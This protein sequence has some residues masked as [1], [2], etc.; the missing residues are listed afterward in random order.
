M[1]VNREIFTEGKVEK[2]L[3]KF[4]IPAIM[5]LLVSELYNMVDTFFVGRYVGPEAI[6][7]LTIAFPIQRLM[8]SI[9]LCIAVGAATNVATYLGK[10]EYNTLYS[11]ITNAIILMLVLM[12]SI[13]MLLYIFLDGVLVHLG[14]SSVILPLA[15]EY[16]SII[17][18]GGLFQCLTFT[19]CYIMNSLG[20]PKIPLVA[21]SIGAIL[22]I[23]IDK[24]LVANLGWGI[25]GAA[26]AT[27]ISQ[28]IGFVFALYRFIYI[29]KEIKLPL[30]LD[31]KGD[32]LLSIV[33]I[34]FPTLIVEISDA[35]VALV[36]NNLL[37]KHGGDSA[38]I[39]SGT[40]TKVSM[41]MYINII[42]ISSGMQPVAAFNFGA[43]DFKRLKETIR[44]TIMITMATSI[45][46]WVFMMI[47]TNPIIASFVKDDTL[48]C[49]SV[50]AYRIMISIFPTVSLYYIAIYVYQAVGK[51]K[52][53]FLLS[54]YRQI[55]IFIP[56]VLIFV[57]FWS[58]L[59]AWI[60]YPAADII[61]AITG[62][63]YIGKVKEGLEKKVQK[64]KMR[65]T[66]V[67]KAY[68]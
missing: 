43:K 59:G 37:L 51:A 11:T 38:I 1:G 46:I 60:A 29:A 34:G 41:F 16:V 53:S 6:G 3:L 35:V 19:M 44:K 5:S 63:V 25:K 49:N 67:S 64:M 58:V 22:N 23:I 56:L 9:G 31:L 33:T 40:I 66:S 17:L 68:N 61:S 62:F 8:A 14:A 39:V 21:T 55:V 7:A 26:F 52:E 27:V 18:L 47:F 28:I 30:K 32:I 4:A 36:L 54:I 20:N 50:Y 48:L 2:V 13:P 57:R 10:R 65:A 12:I 42:G 45:V 15:R 24:I